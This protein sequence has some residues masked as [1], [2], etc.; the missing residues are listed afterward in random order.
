MVQTEPSL[1][2]P[3]QIYLH[4]IRSLLAQVPGKVGGAPGTESSSIWIPVVP[5]VLVKVLSCRQ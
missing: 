2:S 3:E 4:H 1:Q 5:S